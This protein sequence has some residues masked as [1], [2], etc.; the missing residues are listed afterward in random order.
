MT[1]KEDVK[2]IEP[3]V[4]G[5][6]NEKKAT[7]A[8]P[9]A[10]T[11][12]ARPNDLP[13]TVCMQAPSTTPEGKNPSVGSL[14]VEDS[15]LTE[16]GE[17]A[18]LAKMEFQLLSAR[19][20]DIKASF[21]RTCPQFLALFENL[22]YHD[23]AKGLLEDLLRLVLTAVKF[24]PGETLVIGDFIQITAPDL[25]KGQRASVR[26]CLNR[27]NRKYLIICDDPVPEEVH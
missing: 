2:T 16:K 14:H 1:D 10:P 3:T 15:F 18:L 5:S 4:S 7:K 24:M 6:D 25:K 21:T 26:F 23:Q 19:V 22:Q 8:N 27:F 12:A 9:V 17:K 13:V 20:E 11:D